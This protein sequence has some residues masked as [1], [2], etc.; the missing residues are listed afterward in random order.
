MTPF[1]IGPNRRRGTATSALLSALADGATIIIGPGALIYIE[2]Y[3]E[4]VD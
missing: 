2:I 4:S 1:E 3:I